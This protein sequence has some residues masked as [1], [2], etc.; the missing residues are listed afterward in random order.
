MA[1]LRLAICNREEDPLQK[2]DDGNTVEHDGILGRVPLP[3]VIMGDEF[4][5]KASPAI[6]RITETRATDFMMLLCIKI[7][8]TL[9]EFEAPVRRYKIL[10]LHVRTSCR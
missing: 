2:N 3:V 9:A 4:G 7:E 5:W 6:T 8:D 10:T 1:K